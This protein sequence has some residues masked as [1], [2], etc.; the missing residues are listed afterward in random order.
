M[1]WI[2]PAQPRLDPPNRLWIHPGLR[3]SYNCNSVGHIF[4]GQIEAKALSLLKHHPK[5]VPTH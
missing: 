3:P 5:E 4:L 2:K 1:F